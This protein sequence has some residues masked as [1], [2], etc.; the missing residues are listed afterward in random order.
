ML[1][2][3]VVFGP[4]AL[5]PFVCSLEMLGNT[6]LPLTVLFSILSAVFFSTAYAAPTPNDAIAPGTDSLTPVDFPYPFESD[7]YDKEKREIEKREDYPLAPVDFPFPFESFEKK[8]EI[9]AKREEADDSAFTPV[10][11]PYPYESTEKRSEEYVK[12]RDGETDDDFLAPVDFPY[13]YET[14]DK[15]SSDAGVEKRD[16][17]IAKRDDTDYPFAPVDFPY[18]YSESLDESVPVKRSEIDGGGPVGWRFVSSTRSLVLRSP[19]TQMNI[20]TP[21]LTPG[22]LLRPGASHLLS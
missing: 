16:S 12:K 9:V 5:H 13:P 6:F 22:T 19:R 20:C 10:D 3:F 2:L 7:S 11:F 1:S 15:R 17:D 21:F 14:L 18:P 8:A 4:V